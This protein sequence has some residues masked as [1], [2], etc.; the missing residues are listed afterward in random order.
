[1]F[2]GKYSHNIDEKGRVILPA[3]FRRALEEQGASNKIIITGMN[4]CLSMY[5][6]EEWEKSVE[7]MKQ[8]AE[9]KPEAEYVIRRM[10][11][12]AVECS[13]DEQGRL[14]IP[15]NLKEYG[16]L[17]KEVVTVGRMNK[18]EIWDKKLWETEYQKM[19]EISLSENVTQVLSGLWI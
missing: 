9:S 11:A 16:G 5:T 4:K 18:L 7:K 10:C 14:N 13:I 2:V 3:S 6:R 8:I 19:V 1:M 17:K 15:L 12:D